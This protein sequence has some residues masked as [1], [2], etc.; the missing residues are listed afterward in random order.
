MGYVMVTGPCIRCRQPFSYNPHHVPST[1]AVTGTREP[2]C[3]DCFGWL[4]AMRK[5]RGLDPFPLHPEAYEPLPEEE[6]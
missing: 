5:E 6:L 1:S 4:N 3:R 2:F